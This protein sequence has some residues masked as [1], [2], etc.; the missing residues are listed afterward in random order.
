MQSVAEWQIG[1]H[2]TSQVVVAPNDRQSPREA[3]NLLTE[4]VLGV[5]YDTP[6]E[7]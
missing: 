3:G 6:V 7:I 1:H 4:A 2:D 5:L